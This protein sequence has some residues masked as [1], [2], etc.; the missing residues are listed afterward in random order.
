MAE[1]H[2]VALDGMRLTVVADRAEARSYVRAN[3]VVDS[4]NSSMFFGDPFSVVVRDDTSPEEM[5]ALLTSP[6][7]LYIREDQPLSDDRG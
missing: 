3:A 6:G 5:K 7:I 1:V 2:L 4:V